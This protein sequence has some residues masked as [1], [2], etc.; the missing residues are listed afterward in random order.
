[1]GKRR[2]RRW[3]LATDYL[4]NLGILDADPDEEDDD[5]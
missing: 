4:V 1:M 5:E 2:K 3:G